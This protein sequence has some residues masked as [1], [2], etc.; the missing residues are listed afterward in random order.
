MQLRGLDP[1]KELIKE[2]E[3]KVFRREN[4]DVGKIAKMNI[5]SKVQ[6]AHSLPPTYDIRLSVF[7]FELA[8]HDGSITCI[9]NCQDKGIFM[10]ASQDTFV[11][12]W[13]YDGEIVGAIGVVNPIQ[14]SL[15]NLISSQLEAKRSSFE[16]ALS[17]KDKGGKQMPNL[18][19]LFLQA[20]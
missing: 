2:V 20:A 13:K 14:P 11:K 9:S 3:N 7:G 5:S 17:D 10:T 19:M 4:L 18:G 8:A 6:G 1:R 16:A 15:T 12:I